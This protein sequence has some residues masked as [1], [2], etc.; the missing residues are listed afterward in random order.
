MLLPV[1]ILKP[2]VGKSKFV[3]FVKYNAVLLQIK[4]TFLFELA[5]K[6]YRSLVTRP[7]G[8]VKCL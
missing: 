7:M 4:L 6:L 8:A 1:V 5:E 2:S 3:H